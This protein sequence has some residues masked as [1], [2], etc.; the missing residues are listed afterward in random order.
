[1]SIVA[2]AT[3]ESNPSRTWPLRRRIVPMSLN[4]SV[5]WP[6][7]TETFPNKIVTNR[8]PNILRSKLRFM[9][10]MGYERRVKLTRRRDFKSIAE[11]MM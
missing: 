3:G 1:M 10:F 6:T 4:V 9:V 11:V 2:P 8:T 7:T 5:N